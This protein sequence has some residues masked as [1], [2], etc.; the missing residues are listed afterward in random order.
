LDI[1][2]TLP[3]HVSTKMAKSAVAKD[4]Y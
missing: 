1:S 2:C 3:Y 4:T